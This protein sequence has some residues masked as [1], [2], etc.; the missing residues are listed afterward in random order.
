VVTVA[1]GRNL[2]AQL[3]LPAA[4]L[5]AVLGALWPRGVAILLAAATTAEALSLPFAMHLVNR[6]RPAIAPHIKISGVERLEI[7]DY[8]SSHVLQR[9][10]LGW[11]LWTSRLLPATPDQVAHFI[12]ATGSGI[13]PHNQWL[14][15]W[16]ETGFL[17]VLLGLAIVLL[18][19]WRI[20]ELSPALRPFAYGAFTMAMAVASA[21]F[22]ITT[23]SWWA[24]LSA[25]A[26]LFGF[27]ERALAI[28]DF[29]ISPGAMPQAPAA[30]PDTTGLQA[31][32]P[33]PR[34]NRQAWRV[35][36]PG[37]R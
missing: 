32:A 21:G 30:H 2:T 16:V 19:L 17:G 15:L 6:F 29:R 20:G 26:A 9:P 11:G 31:G 36:V 22:E 18:A 1:C 37:G 23:D 7:W 28:S 24:A 10:L 14:E 35:R 5:V 33:E 27:F 12:K 25:S 4:A 34:R 8:L 13:Y 3:A